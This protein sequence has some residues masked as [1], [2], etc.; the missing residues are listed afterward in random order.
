MLRGFTREKA[1]EN[2]M[3]L[4]RALATGGECKNGSCSEEVKVIQD[5]DGNVLFPKPKAQ[6]KD[7]LDYLVW[8]T[9]I[10]D[11][12]VSL[13]EMSRLQKEQREKENRAFEEANEEFCKQF[14][15]DMANRKRSEKKKEASSEELVQ[16]GNK[17]FQRRQYDRALTSYEA[18]LKSIP[19]NC[20]ALRNIAQVYLK[21]ERYEEALEFS[22]RAVFLEQANTKNLWRRSRALENL[23]KS[24]LMQT[25]AHHTNQGV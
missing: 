11:D 10:P 23:G 13:E 3:E 24:Q 20:R 22:E 16:S 15:D 9:W 7:V 21:Q 18:A 14:K 6:G 19:W 5:D 4:L 25:C 2:D 12:P 17:A 8:E 1:F